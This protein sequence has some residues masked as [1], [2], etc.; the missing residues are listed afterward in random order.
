VPEGEP[1]SFAFAFDADRAPGKSTFVAHAHGDLN[2]NGVTS[3]F[4]VHG[5]AIADE[6]GP[7][8]EPGLYIQDEVE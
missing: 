4:E 8:L 5:R 2:G 6:P 3:T 7:V 1:H